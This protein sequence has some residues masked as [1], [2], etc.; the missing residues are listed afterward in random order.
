MKRP[1]SIYNG[2]ILVGVVITLSCAGSVP[3]TAEPQSTSKPAPVDSRG[4]DPLELPRDREVLALKYDRTGDITGKQVIVESSQGTDL[5]SLEA[6]LV[7]PEVQVDTLNSQVYRIQ[8]FT[9]RVY[10]DGHQAAKVA[11]E[12]FDQPVYMDY[13]VPNYKV[14]VGNFVDRNTAE[15]Y[16]QRARAAGYSNA[17]VVMVNVGIREVAP[18]YEEDTGLFLPVPE[19]KIDTVATEDEA[20]GDRED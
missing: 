1:A 6:G 18:L 5:D 17:W 10:G 4:F 19:K 16:Q 12:I 13:K 15:D 7:G 2:L 3:K 8:L 9:S 14:R 20:A 11:E